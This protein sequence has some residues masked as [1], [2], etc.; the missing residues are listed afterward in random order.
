MGLLAAGFDDEAAAVYL[1]SHR[2]STS[3]QYQSVWTKFLSFFNSHGFSPQ[4][5]SVGVVCN[6]LT[7]QATVQGLQYRTLTGYRSALRLPLY[8]GCGLEI[9]TFD[10]D[11]FLRGLFNWKPPRRAAPMPFWSLN[12]LLSFLQSGRFEPLDSLSAELITQKTL[13][14][15]LLASGRRISEIASLS[16]LSRP[17]PSGVS[18]TLDWVPD[19]RPKHDDPGFRPA[20]PSISFLASDGSV[21]LSLSGPSLSNFSPFFHS[22]G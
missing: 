5:A 18:M 21:S 12:V 13:C 22:M 19:F 17:D 11:Q 1:Q 2:I 7:F 16:R 8:W 14:L 6:F 9:N 3:R 10:S 15:L 4:D 20:P